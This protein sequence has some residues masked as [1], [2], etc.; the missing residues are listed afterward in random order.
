M[1]IYILKLFVSRSEDG[2]QKQTIFR[3]KQKQTFFRGG[4]IALYNEAKSSVP[5][6]LL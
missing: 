6:T 3:G 2:K 4:I 5:G 1:N